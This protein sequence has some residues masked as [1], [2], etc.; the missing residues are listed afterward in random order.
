MT[1]TAQ[2]SQTSPTYP[3]LL[4]DL[5]R[6][7][8]ALPADAPI[9]LAK[10]TSNVFRLRTPAPTTGL[11][12]SGFAG[13]LEV[14]PD[15]ATADVLG[16]TTYEALVDATLPHGLMPLV[17]PQLKTI[18]LGGAVTGLGIES[19]SFRDGLPHESVLEMDILTGAGEIVTATADN[20]HSDLYYAFPNSYGTLGYALRLKIALAPV[21]GFVALRHVRFHNLPDAAAAIESITQSKQW[22]G[23]TVDFLDGTAFG[24]DEIYLTLGEWTDQP[25]QDPSDYT[26]QN[27]YYKSIRSRGRDVLTARD[28]IWRWD[29]D[30]FWCSGGLGLQKPWIRALVPQRYL[31]SDVYHR[32]VGFS[33]RSGLVDTLARVRRRPLPEYVIQDVEVPVGRLAEFME[34]FDREVGI[35]PV[36]LCPLKVRN[37]ERMWDLYPLDPDTT[38]V[39]VGFWSSVPIKPGAQMGDVNRAIEAEVE[40]LGGRKSLYSDSY[41]TPE[42][43]W[44]IYNGDTYEQVKKT[45]DPDGRLLDLYDKCVGRR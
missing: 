14:D 41:Y 27:I 7:W 28:Y 37:T 23:E 26:D 20:E 42:A 8:Q 15:A 31:R 43:F 17:V 44:Q 25:A 10:N 11:D 19:T 22:V 4:D 2:R 16:M 18:T 3:A 6:Q 34:F 39:N 5:Q 36:W 30:W 24:P 33:R 35:T 40:R 21:K 45:Y 9:R 32:V 38:Y 29:T 1:A 13:V 12:V